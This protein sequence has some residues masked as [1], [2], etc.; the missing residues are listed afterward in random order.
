MKKIVS[1]SVVV[2]DPGVMSGEPCFRGTRVP[3]KTLID[4]VEE[5]ETIDEF[6][7]DFPTVGRNQVIAFLEQ[8][9]RLMITEVA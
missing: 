1:T 5:G 2:R 8:A 9:E 4:Y 6:L 3:V 7:D